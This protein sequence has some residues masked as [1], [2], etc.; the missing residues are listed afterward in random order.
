MRTSRTASVAAVTLTLLAGA[1]GAGSSAQEGGPQVVDPLEDG[2]VPTA[3]EIA[4][5]ISP[6]EPEVRQLEVET[7]S[8]REE[9]QEDDLAIVSVASDVLFPFDSA[10]LTQRAEA[11]VRDLAA[12][13]VDAAGTVTVVG[14]T[15]SVGTAA[16]N[17]DLSERRAAAVAAVLEE[18][19]DGVEVVTEG[20]GSREP[21]VRESDDDPSA[22]ARNRRVEIGY[23]R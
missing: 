20:R 3:A 5:S 14:H 17:Q 11:T 21:L 23:E 15:D 8:L 16:Y 7:R 19:L 2:D 18:E 22:A 1:G 6:L 13:L 12:D 9:R 10:E 4:D